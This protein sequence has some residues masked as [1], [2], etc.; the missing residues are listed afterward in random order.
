MVTYVIIRTLSTKVSNILYAF[1]QDHPEIVAIGISGQK[2]RHFTDAIKFYKDNGFVLTYIA[3]LLEKYPNDLEVYGA[4][5][6]NKVYFPRIIQRGGKWLAENKHTNFRFV[7]RN[8]GITEEEL[9]KITLGTKVPIHS[10][11]EEIEEER[12]KIQNKNR[13]V[14]NGKKKTYRNV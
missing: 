11:K 13:V 4:E 2:K 10:V 8:I 9:M 12:Q 3:G 7:A 14:S 6:I 5:K 1:E